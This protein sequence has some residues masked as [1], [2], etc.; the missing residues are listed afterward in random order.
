MKILAP[1]NLSTELWMSRYASDV[2]ANSQWSRL[3]IV[4]AVVLFT[5]LFMSFPFRILDPGSRTRIQVSRFCILDQ[6]SWI[7]VQD[8]AFADLNIHS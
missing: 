3:E 6:W 8:T 5:C 4:A 7:L 2:T 1:W